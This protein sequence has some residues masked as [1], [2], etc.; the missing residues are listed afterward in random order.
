M[1][2]SGL[3]LLDF[4]PQVSHR[5]PVAQ[6]IRHL[7]TNQGIAGS[8][9]ARVIFFPLPKKNFVPPG[10]RSG[11]PGIGLAKHQLGPR[12]RFTHS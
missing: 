7:T 12:K 9:P 1:V 2:S 6:R 4:P 5:G 10:T 11:Y 3:I 8:S